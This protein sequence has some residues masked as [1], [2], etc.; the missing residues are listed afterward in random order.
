MTRDERQSLREKAEKE[1]RY[2]RARLRASLEWHLGEAL[3]SGRG[4][5]AEMC[6][7][8]LQALSDLD[9]LEQEN[10]R[11]R[12]YARHAEGCSAAVND[13]YRCRCGFAA[14]DCLKS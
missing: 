5:T 7:S 4:G 13:I 9:R 11:L 8:S 1:P 3:D 14:L 12:D 2:D 6:L 10:A